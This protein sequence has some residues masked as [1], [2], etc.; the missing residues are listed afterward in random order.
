MNLFLFERHSPKVHATHHKFIVLAESQ[1]DAI[2]KFDNYLQDHPTLARDNW[3]P[4]RILSRVGDGVFA[5]T[6]V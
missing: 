6:V 4:T 5:A 1:E 3:I 2:V